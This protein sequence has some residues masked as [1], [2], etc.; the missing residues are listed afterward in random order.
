MAVILCWTLC[1]HSHHARCMFRA[2]LLV[3]TR[4]PAVVQVYC[5]SLNFIM[6][7]SPSVNRAWWSFPF[8]SLSPSRMAFQGGD[9]F[10]AG[11]CTCVYI[12]VC[13]SLSFS[14][15]LLCLFQVST[16]RSDY[17]E[18]PTEEYVSCCTVTARTALFGKTTENRLNLH[19]QPE[20]RQQKNI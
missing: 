11:V 15:F 12:C 20:Y 14:R 3:S 16:V 5:Q 8:Y 4:A 2:G 1:F 10:S 9:C 17:R 6:T 13:I 7:A 19:C 18:Q